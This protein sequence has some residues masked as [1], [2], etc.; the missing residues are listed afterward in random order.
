M[1]LRELMERFRVPGL[2]VAV[3]ADFQ[4]VWAKAYGIKDLDS[5]APVTVHTIEAGSISKPVSAVSALSLV[6]QGRISVDENGY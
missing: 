4:I 3:I 2:S 5:H 1:N 6:E